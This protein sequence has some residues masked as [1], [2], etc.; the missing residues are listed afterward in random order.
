MI[1][2]T[3]G[4]KHKKQAKLQDAAAIGLTKVFGALARLLA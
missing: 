2:I 4:Q 3:G 1:M